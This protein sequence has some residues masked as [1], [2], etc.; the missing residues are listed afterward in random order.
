M[1]KGKPA[2]QKLVFGDLILPA[3]R[4]ARREQC[5]NTGRPLG[6][7]SRPL[8]VDAF[9]QDVADYRWDHVDGLDVFFT[10]V[11]GLSGTGMNALT[12]SPEVESKIRI[13]PSKQPVEI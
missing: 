11:S 3:S 1:P 8:G 2:P 6:L 12:S 13:F 10:M 9:F 7:G 5:H 4:Q